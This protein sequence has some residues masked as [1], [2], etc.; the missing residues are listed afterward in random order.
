MVT[1]T[2]ETRPR[3]DPQSDRVDATLPFVSIV[4]PC[5]NEERFIENC[6]ASILAT[7]YPAA[8]AERMRVR[9]SLVRAFAE[10]CSIRFYDPADHCYVLTQ[11]G[12]AR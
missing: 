7:D 2:S 5:L 6:L 4:M 9:E 3:L 8:F 12:P 10:G 1:M 11:G